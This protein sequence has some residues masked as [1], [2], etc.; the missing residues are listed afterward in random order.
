MA[1]ISSNIDYTECVKQAL[2]EADWTFPIK[3][4]DEQ[5]I[6]TLPMPS[7]NLPYINIIF[8]TN[9]IGDSKINCYLA[10]NVAKN[11][12]ID[13]LRTLNKINNKYRYVSFSLDDDADICASYDFMLFGTVENIG[14]HALTMIAFAVKVIENALPTILS[15]V[16]RDAATDFYGDDDELIDELTNSNLPEF[17]N[18]DNM[19]DGETDDADN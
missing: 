18:I 13:V 16:W 12:H 1:K 17:D 3:Q 15:V 9:H 19:F 10:R 7:D 5:A 4:S 11:K 14:K 6:F 8:R 2:T